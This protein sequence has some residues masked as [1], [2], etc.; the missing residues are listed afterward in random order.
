MWWITWKRH[1]MTPAAFPKSAWAPWK[2]W[3]DIA[4]WRLLRWTV[5]LRCATVLCLSL[6]VSLSLSFSLMFLVALPLTLHPKL[7][8]ES[9]GWVQV[10]L[11]TWNLR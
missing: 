11:Q 3:R 4:A 8:V 9:S 5:G 10:E 2:Q 1:E 6:S 7:L